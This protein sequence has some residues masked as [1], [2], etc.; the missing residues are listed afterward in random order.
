[1]H[2]VRALDAA[3]RRTASTVLLLAIS[4]VTL[5]LAVSAAFGHQW[6]LSLG[7]IRLS[8]RN[9]RNP[10]L[11]ACATWAL[12]VWRDRAHKSLVWSRLEALLVSLAPLV[13]LLVA[14]WV[15]VASVRFG[16]F[17]AGGADSSG[18]LSQA[19]MW[20]SLTFEHPL[21]LWSFV[22]WP[23]KAWV[24]TPL[25]YRPART[26]GAVA[27]LYPPGLPLMMAGAQ[28]LTG[29][30]AAF[31]VVPMCA[32]GTVLMAF[33]I[34]RQIAGVAAGVF[35]AVFLACSPIFLF[36]AFQPMSDVPAAFWW[37]LTFALL[38]RG[39][40]AATVGA[41]MAAAMAG[42]VRPNLWMLVA[43][44]I[45]LVMW[46]RP[47]PESPYKRVLLFA[48]GVAPGAAAFVTWN[49]ALYGA[50]TETGYGPA[51]HSLALNHVWPNVRFYFDWLLSLHSPV[52]LL[53]LAA[54]LVLLIAG[55]SP[56]KCRE[57]MGA[58]LTALVF[59]AALQLFYWFYLVFD[60]WPFLRFLLPTLPLVFVLVGVAVTTLLAMCGT[61]V[62]LATGW[63]ILITIALFGIHRS[64]ELAVFTLAEGE[65][66]YER[67]A[68]G[69]AS[70]TPP[71]A[72]VF[73]KLHSGSVS[74]YTGRTIARWDAVPP[75]SLATYAR[76]LRALG[77]PS[78][79][80]VDDFER[81]EFDAVHGNE[82][83]V[84]RTPKTTVLVDESARV[85]LF[86]M[87]ALTEPA[88]PE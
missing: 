44:S 15:A 9:P 70:Q 69:V 11:I 42:L 6:L 74:Y 79:L 13:A 18:Y 62:R 26:E 51:S 1:M 23:D 72:V 81:A 30:R 37:T 7:P 31:A 20:R 36:Q 64:R 71:D 28:A 61:P 58:A 76:D 25:G 67:A 56:Q 82:M 16:A 78:Y 83:A 53:G 34:G 75:G 65:A 32:A 35:A 84:A 48:S 50:A 49:R 2:R 87:S 46:W 60:S 22:T 14:L 8:I 21:P 86:D 57:S 68:A 55:G 73:S 17:V 45:P 41:G 47:R 3:W 43:L 19:R 33:L 39:T 27:P 52:L 59:A 5:S 88:A 10:A 40:P 77:R 66:R 85:F 54:P 24:L 63:L 4:F 80:L 12:V 29:E 38:L